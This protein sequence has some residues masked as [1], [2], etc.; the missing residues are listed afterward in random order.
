V[1]KRWEHPLPALLVSFRAALG[2]GVARSRRLS[3]H[4]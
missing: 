2:L 3:R 4:T 1:H